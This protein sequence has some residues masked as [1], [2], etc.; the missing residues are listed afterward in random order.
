VTDIDQNGRAHGAPRRE[1]RSRV[2]GGD[3]IAVCWGSSTEFV[4]WSDVLSVHSVRNYAVITARG[5]AIKV[6][7]T[8]RAVVAELAPL[9]LMQV[10]RDTAVNI[11]RVC[12]LIGAGRHRLVIILDDD[13]RVEVGREFQRQ[14]RARFA[15][16]PPR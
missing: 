6:R 7:S 10:R 13:C 15:S 8:L 1:A 16:A 3:R 4:S 12:R 11:T 5:R 14:V 2:V 9:G